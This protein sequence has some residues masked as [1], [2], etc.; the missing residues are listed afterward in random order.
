MY[1]RTLVACALTVTL[2][3]GCS[4]SEERTTNIPAP[5]RGTVVF[6]MGHGEVFGAYDTSELGQSQAVE[7]VRQAGLEVIVNE[8]AITDDD[9]AEASGL[10][11]AGPMR[12]L[13]DAEYDAITRFAERGGTVLLTIHVPFPVLKVPAHWGLPVGTEILM[14]STPIAPGGEPS[15]FVAD[16]VTEGWDLTEGVGSIAVVSGWPVTATAPEAAIAVATRPDTWL[17]AAGD[18]QSVPPTDAAAFF[19]RGVIGATRVG[20]GIIIVSGD[21]A[22]FA[23]M[24][25]GALDNARLLDNIIELMAAMQDI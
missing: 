18:Q 2:A 3:T 5:V 9:L 25:L 13:K 15:V 10:I 1:R 6:D 19:S 20:D 24:A 16:A 14:S 21:D 7:Q 8:D 17:S 12:P 4:P 22:I 11:V 23:N